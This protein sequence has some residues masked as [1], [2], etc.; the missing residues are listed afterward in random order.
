MPLVL[1]VG[2]AIAQVCVDSESAPMPDPRYVPIQNGTVYD[3]RTGLMWKQ[4]PE[5][6]AGIGCAVGELQAF[7]LD[8]AKRRAREWRFAGYA[9]WRLPNQDELRSLL[10]RRCYGVDIDSVTFPRTPAGPFWTSDPATYY[11]DSAWTLDFGRGHLG[12]GTTRDAFY[13][14]LVR[15]AEACSPARPATCLPYSERRLEPHD[16]PVL[17][18]EDDAD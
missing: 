13:V 14:R 7:K 8:E 11:P 10:Q 12:Y 1:S 3:Q 18:P 9:D 15:D 4:C 16:G 17:A 2:V 5:G 6:V